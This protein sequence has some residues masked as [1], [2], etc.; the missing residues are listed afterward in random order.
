MTS[1][2]GVAVRAWIG[3]SRRASAAFL[4]VINTAGYR[5]LTSSQTET[6]EDCA[7]I[8]TTAHM[9]T[10]SCTDLDRYLCEYDGVAAV[11]SSY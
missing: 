8:D 4:T 11:A 6:T 3:L 5:D 1:T 9:G 10:H 2:Y 7:A